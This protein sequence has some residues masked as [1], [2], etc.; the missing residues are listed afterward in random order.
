M[1]EDRKIQVINK[2]TDELHQDVANLNEEMVDNNKK[3]ALD[4]IK[5]LKQK[6][7][8]LRSNLL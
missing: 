1:K 2:L 7:D 4:I 5:G 8:T 3:E 6:L